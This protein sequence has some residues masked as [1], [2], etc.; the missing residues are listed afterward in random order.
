MNAG[1]RHA[2]RLDDHLDARIGN[3]RFGT[4]GHH[5]RARLVRFVE[6]FGD[7]SAIRPAGGLELAT[8]ARRV[9]IRDACNMQALRQ[10]RL[11]Q[12]H[13]AKLAGPD[14]ADGDRLSLGFAFQ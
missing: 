5:S 14:H 11:R 9:E 6:R 2:G 10:P 3:Q 8:G 13:G 12:K 4:V 1:A 7:I